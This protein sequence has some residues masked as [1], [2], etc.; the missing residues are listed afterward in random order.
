MINKKSKERE[1]EDKEQ[2]D[3]LLKVNKSILQSKESELTRV[4]ELIKILPGQI[5]HIK[6]IISKIEGGV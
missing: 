5:K 4:Q 1:A 6:E 3:H 2:L